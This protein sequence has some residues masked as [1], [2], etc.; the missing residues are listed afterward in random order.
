MRSFP[1]TSVE[2]EGENGNSLCI[3]IEA[4][5]SADTIVV[6]RYSSTSNG[7]RI[8]FTTGVVDGRSPGSAGG[9]RNHLVDRV[10]LAP[11]A[12]PASATSS[13]IAVEVENTAAVA[14]LPFPADFGG[15]GLF[16]AF[17]LACASVR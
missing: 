15:L 14:G 8:A 10:R 17:A 1:S 5:A 4:E 2:T 13:M 12:S 9:G 3:V 6:V 7:N 11:M 16:L